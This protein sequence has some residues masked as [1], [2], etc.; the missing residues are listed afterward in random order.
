MRDGDGLDFQG[1][2]APRQTGGGA[3][4]DAT[5]LGERHH[6]LVAALRWQNAARVGGRGEPNAD[7]IQLY[8]DKN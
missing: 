4:R 3:P 8:T 7:I 1:R 5:T 2:I 6:L